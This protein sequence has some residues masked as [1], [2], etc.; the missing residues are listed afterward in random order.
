MPTKSKY[1]HQIPISKLPDQV[2]ADRPGLDI[3]EQLEASIAEINERK[4][5]ALEKREMSEK[6]VLK[7]NEWAE[8][9]LKWPDG[10]DLEGQYGPSV[11]FT[12]VDDRVLFLPP[13][14]GAK[15]RALKLA[16]GDRVNVRKAEVNGVN[17][18][19][20]PHLEWQVERVDAPRI[21]PQANG[22]FVV[23]REASIPPGTNASPVS[24]HHG[25]NVKLPY[26]IA[27]REIVSFVSAGLKETGEQ[28]SD[29]ARQ[30]M[31]CTIFIQ[32][33]KDGLLTMWERA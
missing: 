25:T 18:T 29:Q 16:P 33:S 2:W 11:M 21:G 24:A 26:D 23:P 20:P 3:A 30:A 4:F 32:A 14:A 7:T 6:I 22:T 9:A 10:K 1:R 15:V 5:S 13:L 28:W 17:G 12:T 31:V 27:F 19:K 8:L